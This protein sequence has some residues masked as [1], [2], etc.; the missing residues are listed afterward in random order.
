MGELVYEMVWDCRYCKAQKLLGLT[1]RHCPNC[2]AP[3]DPNARYFPAD[4]EKVAVQNHQYVGADV[5][6]RYCGTPSSRMAHNCG[7]CG[8]PLAEGANVAALPPQVPQQLVSPAAQASA[9]GGG[10]SAWIVIVPVLALMGVACVVLAVLWKKE[11][12]FV[13]A[14]HNWRRSIA[15]EWLGPVRESAW[16]SELLSGASVSSRH[17]EQHGSKQVADGEDCHAE[18]RDRGDGT[19]KEEQVCKPKTKSEPIYEDKCDYEVV[20][21][22][23]ERSEKAEGT[24]AT[25]A[26]YWPAVSLA[27]AG[28]SS[29]G[30]EREGQRDETYTVVFKDDKGESYRCDFAEPAWSGYGDGK[31]YRG[32]LRAL[33]GSLDCSSLVGNR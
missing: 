11:Q 25:P 16:C 6:C 7:R 13:V 32:K 8:A 27:R 23:K 1:H 10:R 28:C 9:S 12:G 14:A 4:N 24:A 18:K 5:A 26:P 19:F 17:R 33:V 22:S 29:P 21:W 31:H 3:Q 15:V 20:K 2:G 30:C